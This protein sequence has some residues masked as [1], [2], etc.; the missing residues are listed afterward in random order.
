MNNKLLKLKPNRND[1]T[2]MY[3]NRVGL[4]KDKKITVKYIYIK[5][6]KEFVE[7]MH[8]ARMLLND[9]DEHKID[10]ICYDAKGDIQ[11]AFR[12][13]MNILQP[14]IDFEFTQGFSL[15]DVNIDHSD[16]NDEHSPI[17]SGILLFCEENWVFSKVEV[18][19]RKSGENYEN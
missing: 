16:I 10:R 18:L 17:F 13:F 5:N 1:E 4:L 8:Y 9:I 14:Q 2:A 7:V 15:E 19:L 3:I 12:A 6:G 11:S